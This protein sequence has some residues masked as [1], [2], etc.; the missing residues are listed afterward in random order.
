MKTNKLILILLSALCMSNAS[1][2]SGS[3]KYPFYAGITAGYGN[4]TWQGLVPDPNKNAAAMVFATPIRADEGGVL[5][6]AA[7]GYEFNP[8]FALEG[9]YSRYPNAKVTFNPD[10]TISY[11]TFSHQISNLNTHTETVAINAKIMM[12]IPHTTIRAY[13]C[14]G[15]A[16]IHRYDQ[17]RERWRVTPAFGAGLNYNFT[18]HIMGEFGVNYT[19]G[20]GVSEM[21]PAEDYLPFLYSAF[22]RVAYR[23]GM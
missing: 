22:L 12:I 6:G 16:G 1:A 18:D 2:L 4:T 3:F 20:Y 5:W 7:A 15:P 21:S 17:I 9:S 14:L 23:F 11:F 19:A 8:Y 13:S 10:P